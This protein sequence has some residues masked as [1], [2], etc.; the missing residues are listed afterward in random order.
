MEDKWSKEDIQKIEKLLCSNDETNIHLGLELMK[1]KPDF[2]PFVAVVSFLEALGVVDKYD[3]P[4]IKKIKKTEAHRQ[5]WLALKI[6]NAHWDIHE[7][8]YLRQLEAYEKYKDC[9]EKFMQYN[10]DYSHIY[11]HIGNRL[12]RKFEM[13][14]KGNHYFER[15]FELDPDFGAGHFDYA[16]ALGRENEQKNGAKIVYHYEQALRTGLQD[17]AV[18][19]NL[20]KAYFSI[21]RN[22]KKAEQMFRDNLQIYPNYVNT[23][24]ELADIVKHKD[25]DEAENLY[26]K[27]VAID[28]NSDVAWN[29]MAFFYFD[30]LK[31]YDEAYKAV[32]EAIKVNASNPVYWHTLAE[33]EWYGFDNADDALEALG[34][35]QQVDPNY[36][37]AEPMIQEILNAD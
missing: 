28:P 11:R 33:I 24:V 29:N 1:S 20:G 13:H 15:L 25:I 2:S 10:S 14:E 17:R 8:Q 9:F 27:A 7:D 26:Q 18:R 22:I 4:F 36:K 5:Y 3:F 6:V 34:M 12:K 16:F 31:D 30:K 35:A 32:K 23:L 19:H 37:A 21:E